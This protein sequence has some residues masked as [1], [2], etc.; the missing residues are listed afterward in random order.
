MDKIEMEKMMDKYKAEMIEFSRRNNMSGYPDTMVDTNDSREK[1]M[2]EALE[3]SEPFERDRSDP[4]PE[5]EP[6]EEKEEVAVP[7]QVN[8]PAEETPPTLADKSVDVSAVLRESCSRISN[9][10]SSE[11]RTKCNEIT[12]FLN[13]NSERGTLRVE[14]F[15]SDRAFGVGS[16]RV[17]VF[18]Q[19]PS[20]N[21]AVFDGL[22][23]IDGQSE[24]IILPAPPRSISQSPQNGDNPK[25]PYA[26][27]SVY[28]EHPSYVRAVFT[29]VPVFSGVE[30]I[31]PVRMLAK[32]AGL[33]EP[34]PI[35]VDET[36][37]VTLER[38]GN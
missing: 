35:A 31:Q 22:T 2:R 1:E 11:Q 14:T 19:L 18:V 3:K 21:I 32:A 8:L 29:N 16:A 30:S 37:R 5:I 15:A 4:L 20:G 23:D 17:M 12:E 25:L 24:T 36:S 34:E 33:P 9:D 7:A 38:Q 28:V 13:T 26:V 10:S 27:Y 6:D